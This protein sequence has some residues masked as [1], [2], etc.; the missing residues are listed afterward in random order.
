M[1]RGECALCHE[2]K[3]LELSHIVPKFANKFFYPYMNDSVKEFDYDQETYY[4]LTSVSWR[5][6]YLDILDFVKNHETYEVDL[7]TLE[8]LVKREKS[9]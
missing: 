6:L 4:F 2:N 3:E 8:T 9:M 7:N 1:P 5:S